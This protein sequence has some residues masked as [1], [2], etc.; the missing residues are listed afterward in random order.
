MIPNS[1]KCEIIIGAGMAAMMGELKVGGRI[2]STPISLIVGSIIS[3]YILFS[4][5][6][7]NVIN[8]FS[9]R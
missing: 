4:L 6:F 3:A 8:E 7:K 2:D 5:S 1:L 9:K